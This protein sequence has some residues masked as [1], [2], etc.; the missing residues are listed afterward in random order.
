[1]IKN[2]K[3]L[4]LIMNL[5]IIGTTI[6][7]LSGCSKSS[8][9][10]DSPKAQVQVQ[11]NG[12]TD[13]EVLIGQTLPL[14]GPAAAG[15]AM[16]PGEQAY[17][18]Y[19]NEQGGVNGRQIKLIVEDDQMTPAQTVA[20]V[21]KLIEQDKVFGLFAPLGTAPLLAVKDYLDQNNVLVTLPSTASSKF[22]GKYIFGLIPKYTGEGQVQA[23]FAVETLKAN[24]ISIAYQNDD[25]GKEASKGAVDALAAKYN[26][27]PVEQIAIEATA[28]DLSAEALK[29]KNS[30]ADVVISDNGPKVS[31]ALINEMA[32]IGYKPKIM[33]W[34][35]AAGEI[36][37]DL[38]GPNIDG[39]YADNWV[40]DINSNDAK[41][42]LMKETVKK[43]YPNEN[44][45]A[46]TLDGW[47]RGMI[48]AEGLKR[49][50]KN[51]TLDSFVAG[52]ETMKNWDA[53]MTAPLTY[54]PSDHNGAKAFRFVKANLKTKKMEPL[55]DFITP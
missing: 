15:S 36:M 19:I 5:I 27:K 32:Q 4:A 20:K 18:K 7:L 40:I 38:T 14:T 6:L 51:P 24:K 9:P 34:L 50:G 46:A 17:F 2:H 53:G 45:T 21:R 44:I 54:S 1:M 8:S 26:L 22:T 49:A 37:F 35:Q 55:T 25:S 43:Y 47:N 11:V 48:F 39:A 23:K 52:M 16:L 29:L 31:A 12:V 28:V 42:K 30:G 10:T 33:L 3:S 13:T 41:V